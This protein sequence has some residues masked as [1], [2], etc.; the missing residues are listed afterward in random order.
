MSGTASRAAASLEATL[1]GGLVAT[2][3]LLPA[4]IRFGYARGITARIFGRT[5]LNCLPGI[6]TVP[7]T[8]GPQTI[9]GRSAWDTKAVIATGRLGVGGV[10]SVVA[11]LAY[12]L[13][14]AGVSATVLCSGGGSTWEALLSRGIPAVMVKDLSGAIEAFDQIQPD[15][16]ELHNAPDYMAEAAR[17]RGIPILPVVHNTEIYRTPPE[18]ASVAAIFQRARLYVAVSE[19]VRAHH[20]ANLP[21]GRHPHGVVIPNAAFMPPSIITLEKRQESRARLSEALACDLNTGSFVLL[22]LAR[23]DPQKNIPGLVVAFLDVAPLNP[24]LHLVVAGD[25]ADWLEVRRADALRR[26]SPHGDRVHLL[27]ASNPAVLLAAADVFVLD[28]FHEGWPMAATEAGMAGLPLVM[29]R[30]GGAEELIGSRSERG[31]L[32]A[33]PA[34][35]G[36]ISKKSVRLARV[37]V[38]RQRNRSELGEALSAVVDNASQWAARRAAIVDQTAVL[39]G[40][41]SMIEAHASALRAAVLG[42]PGSG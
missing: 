30:V 29:A 26:S 34:T 2:V 38:T 24:S 19:T 23:Y 6:P 21:T 3:D 18:W 27:R 33:N 20:E 9:H 5:K 42:R 15:V 8:Q 11:A 41:E 12:G 13:P 1:L 10:E 7:P 16:A 40:L 32:V 31:M 14:G 28:S 25:E 37:R 4:H 39:T 17:I 35:D 22:S 36:V